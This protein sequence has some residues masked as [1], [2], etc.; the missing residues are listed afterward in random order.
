MGRRVPPLK[1]L[2]PPGAEFQRIVS[3][4]LWMSAAKL[5]H[6]YMGQN[7]SGRFRGYM[8]QN[9]SGRFRFGFMGLG[10]RMV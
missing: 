7:M 10:F 8:G 5:H 9:M 4:Y 3:C 1:T 6:S 2:N